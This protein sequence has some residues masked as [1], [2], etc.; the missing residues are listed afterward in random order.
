VPY[1]QAL[2]SFDQGCIQPKAFCGSYIPVLLS[3]TNVR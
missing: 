2:L 1:C 3:G